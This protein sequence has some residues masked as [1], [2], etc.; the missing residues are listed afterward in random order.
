MLR[1]IPYER[2]VYDETAVCAGNEVWDY[3]LSVE[4][5]VLRRNRL[6]TF[7]S[8]QLREKDSEKSLLFDI[9]GKCPLKRQGKER[10]FSKKKC[11]KILQNMMSMIQEVDDYMLNLNCIEWEPEYIYEESEEE[12]QWIYFPHPCSET[13]EE[14]NLSDRNIQNK[15][16]DLQKRVESLFA[17]MLTQIDYEDTDAVQYMY[18]FYN[19][20]RKQGFS[21][22]L[23]ENYIQSELQKE[24]DD[25]SESYEAYIDEE[26][27]Y[28]SK[29][30][31]GRM[32]NSRH[33]GIQNG[34]QG[35]MPNKDQSTRFLQSN[36]NQENKN[37][38]NRNYDNKNKVNKN[39]N[40]RNQDS[41]NNK[42]QTNRNQGNK[43]NKNQTNRNQ[44]NRSQDN[45]NSYL[46]LYT[47]LKILSAILA[48]VAAGL[49]G[50]FVFYGMKSGFTRFLFQY[51]TGAGLLIIIF[52]CGF[53]WSTRKVKTI[54]QN[55]QKNRKSNRTDNIK[56]DKR[57]RCRE[58]EIPAE[59]QSGE[60]MWED[61]WQSRPSIMRT[62]ADWEAEPEETAVLQYNKPESE[63]TTILHYSNAS[64]TE[65]RKDKSYPMLRDMEL[66]IVYIIKSCPFYIGSAEGVNHLQIHDKTVSREHAV[67][68]E[69]D[70]YG[71]EEQ[72]YI[73]RDMDSTNGTWIDEKR[74]KRGRQEPLE[75]GAV[76]RFAKK[77]YEFLIQDI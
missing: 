15:D 46:F 23:L 49:E 16:E 13:E 56:K 4:Y 26:E 34:R 43:N 2:S 60:F 72:G 24:H 54:K 48:L 53:I 10:T 6:K 12:I 33:I 14:W 31:Q 44:A 55:S 57:L 76:I 35:S 59:Q 40:N 70:M 21:K 45:E 20:V 38:N 77:E 37:Q 28:R 29:V 69:A 8:V 65:E 1:Q 67:I 39:Q 75:E 32:D 47:S 74:I 3:Y 19:K 18:R 61:D 64:E 42:N 5:E 71:G 25:I 22:E 11:E 17:W 62:E 66:G 63:G 9:T 52:V 7:I 41:R 36:K 51:S 68:L 50:I 73:L 58:K 30:E 27:R